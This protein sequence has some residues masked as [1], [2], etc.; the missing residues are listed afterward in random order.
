MGFPVHA[1]ASVHDT[2]KAVKLSTTF[3]PSYEVPRQTPPTVNDIPD[4]VDLVLDMKE[5]ASTET[6]E[7]STKLAALPDSYK[8]WI[9]QQAAV[10]E[11]DDTLAPY[12]DVAEDSLDS[13][14]QTLRRIRSGIDLISKD[15]QAAEAFR[16][17]NKAM[18]LQ[19]VRSIYSEKCRRGQPGSVEDIDTVA[20]RTWYPFQIAFLLLNLQASHTFIIPNEVINQKRLRIVWFPYRRRKD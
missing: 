1:E 10:R 2:Q 5:L 20:N 8:L 11:A 13:C 9:R 17:A 18:W 3:V 4:L 7:L 19:R 15:E 6:K 14:G 16:F 12:A